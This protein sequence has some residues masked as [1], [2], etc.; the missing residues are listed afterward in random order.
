MKGGKAERLNLYV[1]SVLSRILTFRVPTREPCNK[2]KELYPL[3]KQSVL[4]S[5]SNFFLPSTVN[6]LNKK[7]RVK[8][9]R[10]TGYQQLE[11]FFTA[12]AG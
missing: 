12:K 10:R 11:P 4:V 6:L 1:C 8:K 9:R 7:A 5:F 2:V 3:K